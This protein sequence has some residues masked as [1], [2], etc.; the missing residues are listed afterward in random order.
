MPG[1]SNLAWRY[2]KGVTIVALAQRHRRYGAGL[3]YLK[4]RQA[5]EIVN[6]KRVERL[7]IEHVFVCDVA[8]ESAGSDALDFI[9]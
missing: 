6:H 4:L 7:F 3:I 1:K 5:G 9:G 8:C 2:S